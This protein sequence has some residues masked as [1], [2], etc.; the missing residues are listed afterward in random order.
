MPHLNA[1]LCSLSITEEARQTMV[2]E[3]AA[4]SAAPSAC[5][6]WAAVARLVRLAGGASPSCGAVSA[7]GS[8]RNASSMLQSKSSSPTSSMCRSTAARPGGL[9]RPPPAG[10]GAAAR[11]RHTGVESC[12]SR[13]CVYRNELVQ[14][15]EDALGARGEATERQRVT[16]LST[17]GSAFESLRT[18]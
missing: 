9:G 8:L 2:V 1:S 16:E 10:S 6:A 17:E 11:R 3:E 13:L 18:A 15:A 5:A 4:V 14:C 7:A 12:K